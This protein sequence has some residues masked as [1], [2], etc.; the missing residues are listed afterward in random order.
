MLSFILSLIKSGAKPDKGGTME[1]MTEEIIILDAGPE[2][3]P[4]GALSV[5]CAAPLSLI[6]G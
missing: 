6:R 3:S 1:N 4:E 5:C 2:D